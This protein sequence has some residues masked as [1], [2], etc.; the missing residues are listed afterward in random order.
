M[1]LAIFDLD[2]TLIDS[3]LDLAHAVNAARA[4]LGLAALPNELISSYVGDGAPV[5]MRRALGPDAPETEVA[6]ALEFFLVYYREHM[7]DN[8]T[9]YP[10]VHNALDRMRHSG[11]KLAILTNKPVR[12]SQ[13]IME[14]LSLGDYFAHIYGG[15]S[16]PFKKPNPIGIE[17]LLAQLNATR[18]KTVM[19]GDSGIDM[20]TAHNARVQA[21]GVTYGFAPET[22]NAHRPDFLVD[23]LEQLA[24]RII[25]P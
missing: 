5:L 17:T 8:T 25:E 9:L 10:G 12:I 4:D 20:E 1:E 14:G 13:A 6:R 11:L 3:K 18:E 22:L 15:N 2:G 23:N 7:L 16:F 24:D 21:C 19:V